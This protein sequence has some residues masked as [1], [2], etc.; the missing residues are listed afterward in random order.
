MM[1]RRMI[2][3]IPKYMFLSLNKPLEKENAS[4]R[5]LLRKRDSLLLLFAAAD[6]R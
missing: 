3:P 6:R 4:K 5:A 2:P 1:I